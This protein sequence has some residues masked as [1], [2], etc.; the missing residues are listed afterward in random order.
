MARTAA[1]GIRVEPPVKEAL[2]KFAAADRRT[3]AAYIEILLVE[4]IESKAPQKKLGS[5]A[6]R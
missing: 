1:I 4:H 6:P 2:E 5:K 3:L